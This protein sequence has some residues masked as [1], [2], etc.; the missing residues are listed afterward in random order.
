MRG[1]RALA[2]AALAGAAAGHGAVSFPRPRQAIDGN[3]APWNGTVPA[4][5][6]PFMFWCATPD[7]GSTQPHNLTGVNGQACFW[8][9]NGCDISCHDPDHPNGGVC[10][11]TTGQMVHPNWIYDGPKGTNNGWT[12]KGIVA[13]PKSKA[14]GGVNARAICPNSG[15]KATLPC[16]LRS[17][18]T[19]EPC[20]GPT[21]YYY[22]APW[23]APGTAPVIDSC[24]VAGGVHKNQ[25]PAAAGGDYHNTTNAVLGD[26][27]SKLPVQH[28]GTVWT[29]GS[30]VEV[31][32]TVKAFH[33]G[34]Y[35]YRLC[36]ADDPLGLTEAC[37]NKYSLKFVGQQSFRWGG[38]GGKQIWFNGTYTQDG[39]YPKGS[40]WAQM[41]I[42]GGPWGYKLHGASIMP[43]CEESPACT[44]A[45]DHKASFMTCQCSG[46][47]VGDIPT[48]EIIDKVH[49]PEDLEGEWVLGWRWD[50]EESTQVWSS[51]SDITIKRM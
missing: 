10:D 22:Y 7:A 30:D 15:R 34:G 32:W 37:F 35:T 18:N 9:S 5:P 13:D 1:A 46:E 31:G 49:I 23:R 6:I 36:R 11:G 3:V 29:A 39:T 21:D 4:Y 47:G 8:F 41:P 16:D 33:G 14:T 24:G 20:D 27:G 25:G 44:S 17:I 51:C 42:P 28:S 43:K 38:K 40:M 48:L 50:C 12:S 19:N 45:V 2:A 26:F